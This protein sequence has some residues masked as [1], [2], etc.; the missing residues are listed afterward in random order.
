M[1]RVSS[2]TCKWHVRPGILG[3]DYGPVNRL[4][5][6]ALDVRTWL[7]CCGPM[8]TCL[9]C[10]GTPNVDGRR[11]RSAVF[12]CTSSFPSSLLWLGLEGAPLWSTLAFLFGRPSCGRLRSGRREWCDACGGLHVLRWSPSTSASSV[13]P[14]RNRLLCCSSGCLE[15]LTLP[16]HWGGMVDVLIHMAGIVRWVVETLRVPFVQQWPRSIPSPWIR[17]WPTPLPI[18]PFQGRMICSGLSPCMRLFCRCCLLN[19]LIRHLC[20]Q[21]FKHRPKVCDSGMHDSK[22]SVQYQERTKG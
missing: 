8:T 10:L 6:R 19:L 22:H 14:Q 16:C 3:L 17:L 12:L 21:T 15:W 5:R 13:A 18:M 20:S 11:Q 9:G 4:G 2:L 7:M 1:N